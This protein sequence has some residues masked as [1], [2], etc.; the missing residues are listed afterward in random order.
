MITDMNINVRKVE[1]SQVIPGEIIQTELVLEDVPV[2]LSN[3]IRRISLSEIPNVAFYEK[4]INVLENKSELHNEFIAHRASLLPIYR[5]ARFKI[6][7]KM[8]K[9]T[10]FR[11]NVFEIDSIIPT[12]VL[13]EHNTDDFTINTHYRDVFS[14]QFRVFQKSLKVL[15]R[16]YEDEDGKVVEE[17]EDVQELDIAN[18]FKPDYFT[19]EYVHFYVLKSN[20]NNEMKGQKLHLE[21]HPTVG[22]AK[23]HASYSPVGAVAFKYEE[24]TD[25]M[26]NM[27]FEKTINQQN[28]ERNSKG[29]TP[30]TEN[31]IMQARRSFD[32]LDAARVYKQNIDGECNSISLTIESIGVYSPLQAFMDSVFVLELKLIDLMNGMNITSDTIKLNSQ[33]KF[34]FENNQ[35]VIELIEQDHTIGNLITDYMKRMKVENMTDF[36]GNKHKTLYKTKEPLLEVASYRIEHPLQNIL[37]FKMKMQKDAKEQYAGS[38]KDN[39]WDKLTRSKAPYLMIFYKTMRLIVHQLNELKTTFIVGQSRKMEGPTAILNAKDK[40]EESAFRVL[41]NKYTEKFFYEN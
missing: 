4:D 12:F 27:I 30:L 31:E 25:E 21:A 1:Y 10:G 13:N 39:T 23:K 2:S 33:Y 29:L 35:A 5:D 34:Y 41:D 22:I 24:D 36:E 18:F 19:G 16:D 8:N 26:K 9:T 28:I 32:R 6:V 20:P 15:D 40:V 7:S 14:N 38:Y 3:A 11:E 37:R 17:V